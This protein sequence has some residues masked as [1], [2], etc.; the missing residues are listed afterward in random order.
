M[1]KDDVDYNDLIAEL[2]AQNDHWF[3]ENYSDL[4]EVK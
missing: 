1:S 3:F 2:V 4:E